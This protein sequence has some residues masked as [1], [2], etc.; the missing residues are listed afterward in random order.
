MI[1]GDNSGWGFGVSIVLRRDDIAAVPG[2]YGWTG[3]Y[4]TSWFS[5]PTEDMVIILL[6]QRLFMGPDD[7]NIHRDF[8]TSAYQAIDD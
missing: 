1:L 2:R 5:D 7:L 4:G 8:W 3:G 6:T